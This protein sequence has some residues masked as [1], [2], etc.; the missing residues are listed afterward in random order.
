MTFKEKCDKQTLFV[1]SPEGPHSNPEVPGPAEPRR[2]LH[3]RLWKRR[4]NLQNWNKVRKYE[5]L[6]LKVENYL[7]IEYL[8]FMQ[9]QQR[10]KTFFVGL[11]YD[12]C[13][14][15]YWL[16]V[17]SLLLN[18][19]IIKFNLEVIH[20]IKHLMLAESFVLNGI[21]ECYFKF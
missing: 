21:L 17:I 14:I 6:I 5:S 12:T 8:Q 9:F 2:K 19:S 20:T 16:F 1:M 7:S 13:L 18:T 3:L 11:F 4:W 15:L 10:A